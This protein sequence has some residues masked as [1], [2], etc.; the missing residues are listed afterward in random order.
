MYMP[1]NITVTVYSHLYTL[2]GSPSWKNCSNPT[3]YEQKRNL[4]FSVSG[5]NFIYRCWY[6][7]VIAQR[8]FKFYKL[9]NYVLVISFI[10]RTYILIRLRIKTASQRKQGGGGEGE[11]GQRNARKFVFFCISINSSLISS[12]F[13]VLFFFLVPTIVSPVVAAIRISATAIFML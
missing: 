3:W 12:C 7:V 4:N 2:R 13:V 1:E 9:F 10:F 5:T 8:S 6:N 11:G